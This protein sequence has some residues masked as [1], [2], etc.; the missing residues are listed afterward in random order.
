MRVS[1]CSRER[2][3]LPT[4]HGFPACLSCVSWVSLPPQYG[5]QWGRGLSPVDSTTLTVS[6]HT[7]ASPF[8]SPVDPK[9]SREEEA[10]R[11]PARHPPSKHGH[12]ASQEVRGASN[13]GPLT[14]DP[15]TAFSVLRWKGLLILLKQYP[16]DEK[17]KCFVVF[18]CEG[19]N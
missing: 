15:Y 10:Q 12:Q 5:P 9:T 18:V 1:I 4:P 3:V 14:R 19:V 7:T 11:Q 8:V 16:P 6:T 2:F 13:R 17:A